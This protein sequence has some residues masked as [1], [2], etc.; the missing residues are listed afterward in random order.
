M[1]QVNIRLALQR[2]PAA[3]AIARFPGAP[4]NFS[5]RRLALHWHL[6][7]VSGR[8]T[9]HWASAQPRAGRCPGAA[10]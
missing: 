8:P 4:V 2:Q 6:D 9:M 1:N 3:L 5:A 10:R 7:P